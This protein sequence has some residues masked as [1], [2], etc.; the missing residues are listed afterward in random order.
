MDDEEIDPAVAQ[1]LERGDGVVGEAGRVALGGQ[2]AADQREL[3]RVGVDDEDGGH[4]AML[5]RDDAQR[6]NATT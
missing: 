4:G 6:V 2:G 1:L 3:L 5:H